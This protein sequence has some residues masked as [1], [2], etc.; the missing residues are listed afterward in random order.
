MSQILFANL[1]SSHEMNDLFLTASI[2]S[3]HSSPR[4]PTRVVFS[5]AQEQESIYDRPTCT[6]DRCN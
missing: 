4:N 5:Q 2:G 1:D 6:Y 3:Q